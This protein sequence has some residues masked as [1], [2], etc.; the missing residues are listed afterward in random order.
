MATIAA[1]TTLVGIGDR[2]AILVTW[3]LVTSSDTCAPLSAFPEYINKSVEVSGTFD[4]STVV[5]NGGNVSG[6]LVGLKDPANAAIT[7][8]STYLRQVQE[9]CLYYQPAHSGGGGSQ[10][11][12]V[13]MLFV[14]PSAP[15]GGN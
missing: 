6:S 12:T 11:V 15:R 8:T 1:T 5:L 4:S 14:K 10:S 13:T 9:N 7:G 2:T 3:P